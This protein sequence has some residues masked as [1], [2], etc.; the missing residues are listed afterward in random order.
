MGLPDRAQELRA[1]AAAVYAHPR[2]VAGRRV[3]VRVGDAEDLLPLAARG[4]QRA[5]FIFYLYNFF[6]FR[7]IYK[8]ERIL[9]RNITSI[10]KVIEKVIYVP[11]SS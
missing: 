9:I 6:L 11:S 5:L 4:G 8:L 2:A 3:V 10:P 1:A 7:S